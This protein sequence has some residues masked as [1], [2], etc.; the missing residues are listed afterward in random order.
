MKI[1]TQPTA[2]FANTHDLTLTPARST[3]DDAQLFR[4]EFEINETDPALNEHTGLFQKASDL[5]NQIDTEKSNMNAMLN[6]AARSTDPLAMNK[7]EGQ[8]SSYY[9]EN[10]LNTKIVSKAVQSL[11]KLT[12]LQ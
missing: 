10:M 5:F 7:V 8:L 1:D 2:F 3:S 4:R 11:D 9:L 6:K 12:N